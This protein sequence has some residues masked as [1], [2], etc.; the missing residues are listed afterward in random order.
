MES[1]AYCNLF[2]EQFVI[3]NE[4]NIELKINDVKSEL[5]KVCELKKGENN[6][7]LIIKNK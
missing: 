4:N 1:D 5:I 7:I 2:G 6:I 3:K